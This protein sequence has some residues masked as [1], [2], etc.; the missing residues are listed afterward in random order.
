MKKYIFILISIM[1]IFLGCTKNNSSTTKDYQVPDSVM[2]VEKYADLD[3]ELA[4]MLCEKY[5][6]K[7]KD[8]EYEEVKEIYN[9]FLQEKNSIYK[10]YGVTDPYENAAWAKKNTKEL[11]EYRRNHQEINYYVIFPEIREANVTIYRLAR[12]ENKLKFK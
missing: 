8:K 10:K 6:S 5:Y 3:F 9:D 2:T 4:S 7:L 1:I 12:A 11:K